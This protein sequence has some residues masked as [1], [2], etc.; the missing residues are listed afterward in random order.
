LNEVNELNPSIPAILSKAVE[1]EK[2][3]E[4]PAEKPVKPIRKTN[5]P[6]IVLQQTEQPEIVAITE[7]EFKSYIDPTQQPIKIRVKKPMPR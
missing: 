3:A 5:K 2:P 6:K 1:T 7:E 4:K